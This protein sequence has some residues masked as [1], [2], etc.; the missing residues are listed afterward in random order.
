[1]SSDLNKEIGYRVRKLREKNGYSRDV[2]SELANLSNTFIADIE[3]G[4]KG[5][6][7]ESLVKLCNALHVTPDYLVYGAT[8]ECDGTIGALLDKLSEADRDRVKE[9]IRVFIKTTE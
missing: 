6:T 9:L 4:K 5:M 1:M 3:S 2:L 8:R 7:V